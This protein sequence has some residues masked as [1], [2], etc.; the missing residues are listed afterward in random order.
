ML[1]DIWVMKFVGQGW[2]TPA[3]ST[4]PNIHV[5][6]LAQVRTRNVRKKGLLVLDCFSINYIYLR[7]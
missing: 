5:A 4:P 6:I 3:L 7:M 1:E 2:Q